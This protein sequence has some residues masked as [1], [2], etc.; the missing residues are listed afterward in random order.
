M[1]NERWIAACVGAALLSALLATYG[2][3]WGGNLAFIAGGILILSSVG[4]IGIGGERRFRLVRNL[5][6]MPIA[7]DPIEPEK[8]QRQISTGV[9]V[10]LLGFSL[11]L[12]LLVIALGS[13]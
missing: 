11:W 13:V 10:F 12:P 3:A 5:L 4:F 2:G 6:G 8:R 7:A 1:R 9:K